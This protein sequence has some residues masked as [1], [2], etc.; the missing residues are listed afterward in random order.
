MQVAK[1][2]SSLAVRLPA[3]VVQALHLKP[4]DELDV[5]TIDAESA[6]LQRK[7]TRQEA[8]ETLDG[9]AMPLPPGFRFDREEANKRPWVERLEVQ[10]RREALAGIGWAEYAASRRVQLSSRAGV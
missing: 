8:L 7:M 2:G 3:A 1:W 5:E 6:R 4:G 9:L 10:L